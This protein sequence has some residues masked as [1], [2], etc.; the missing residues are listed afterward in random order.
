[1]LGCSWDPERPDGL[2][3][4]GHETIVD[5]LDYQAGAREARHLAAH[6]TMVH[7]ELHGAGPARMRDDLGVFAIDELLTELAARA[8][9]PEGDST[10]YQT[11]ISA[12]AAVTRRPEG[13]LRR[14]ALGHKQLRNGPM[15]W[16]DQ[17]ELAFGSDAG[18]LADR[19]RADGAL[20]VRREGQL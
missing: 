15:R 9:A 8:I 6:A 5:L 10:S 7:E 1:M 11:L 20:P 16:R 14:V 13:E 2:V 17:L 3:C 12:A 19:L 18:P 4:L